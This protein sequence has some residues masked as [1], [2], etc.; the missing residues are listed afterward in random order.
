MPACPAPPS[1]FNNLAKRV[2]ACCG[3]FLL[4]CHF[5]ATLCGGL[6]LFYPQQFAD[7]GGRFV[8]LVGVVPAIRLD[9]EGHVGVPEALGDRLGV[10][11]GIEEQAGRC[12]AQDVQPAGCGEFGGFDERRKVALAEVV[13]V[14]RGADL[15][16][17]EERVERQLGSLLCCEFALHAAQLVGK[18]ALHGQGVAQLGAQRDDAARRGHILPQAAPDLLARPALQ[19]TR[20]RSPCSESWAGLACQYLVGAPGY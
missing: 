2:L 1:K 18:V 8:L 13:R 9:R 20:Q 7:L 14:E 5:C 3:C 11:A 12:V 6:G 4:L 19:P 15:G 17:K 16:G 10:D